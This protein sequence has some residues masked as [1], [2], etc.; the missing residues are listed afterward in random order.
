MVTLS[1]LNNVRR[2]AMEVWRLHATPRMT[3]FAAFLMI[4]RARC[5]ALSFD[6]TPRCARRTRRCSVSLLYLKNVEHVS[7]SISQTETVQQS[8]VAHVVPGGAQLAPA[9]AGEAQRLEM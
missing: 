6:A 7:V 3:S 8:T 9:E 4:H 2:R 1:F 5:G